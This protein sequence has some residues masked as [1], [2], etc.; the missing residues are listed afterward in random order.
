MA[1]MQPFW[2]FIPPELVTYWEDKCNAYP[3]G[4]THSLFTSLGLS[5]TDPKEGP[6]CFRFHTT[7][8]GVSTR[9]DKDITPLTLPSKFNFR[10]WLNVANYGTVGNHFYILLALTVANIGI[11]WWNLDANR[12]TLK[13][14]NKGYVGSAITINQAQ[15]YLIRIEVE[16]VGNNV[17]TKLYVNGALKDTK[18]E[19]WTFGD[20]EHIAMTDT[21]GNY[22]VYVDWFRVTNL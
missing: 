19:T 4:W 6:Y 8:W 3:N 10:F 2:W 18:S 1:K 12:V 16:Q 22:D 5:D 17:V 15:W 20:L 7:L 11:G 13:V 9:A 14:Y 21:S